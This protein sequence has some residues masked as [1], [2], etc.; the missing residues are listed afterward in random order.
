M[1]KAFYSI[2]KCTQEKPPKIPVFKNKPVIDPQPIIAPKEPT[3]NY[4]G[5]IMNVNE[6]FKRPE[7]SIPLEK[8]MQWLA[9]SVVCEK[10]GNLL[11]YRHLINDPKYK[12]IWEK[13]CAEN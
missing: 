13:E 11:E 2:T 6:I 10:T 9:N 7:F 5:V 4:K 12:V 3:I 1:K 8:E